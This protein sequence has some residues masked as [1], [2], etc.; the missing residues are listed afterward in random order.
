[1]LDVF[2]QRHRDT[3]AATSLFERLLGEYSVPE[4]VC[5]DKLASYGAAICQLPIMEGVVHQ[6]VMSTARCN[7][8]IEQRASVVIG[9]VLPKTVSPTHTMPG[10]ERASVLKGAELP[11]KPTGISARQTGAGLSRFTRQNYQSSRLYPLDHTR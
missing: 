6:Q 3:L 5:T 11:K 9:A 10:T 8:L 7:T 2:L 4:T 1:M